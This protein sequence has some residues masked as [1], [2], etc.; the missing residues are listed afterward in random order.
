METGKFSDNLRVTEN[1]LMSDVDRVFKGTCS[2]LGQ[3]FVN[4]I[5]FT[6]NSYGKSSKNAQTI[7]ERIEQ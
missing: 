4:N 3:M 7:L 5:Y 1:A 6:W 2:R